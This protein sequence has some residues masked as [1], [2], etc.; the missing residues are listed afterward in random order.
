MSFKYK[1]VRVVCKGKIK[2]CDRCSEIVFNEGYCPQCGRPLWK[3][4]EE[5]CNTI[6]GYVEGDI[7]KKQ[8]K[9][10]FRCRFCNTIT[11]I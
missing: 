9:V 10:N 8:G 5:V 3:K 2:C 11:T 6:V 4:P 7:E 1:M